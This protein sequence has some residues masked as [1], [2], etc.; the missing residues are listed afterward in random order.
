MLNP[1]GL[2]SVY[3]FAGQSKI[4]RFTVDI[5]HERD[6]WLWRAGV[7]IQ[8]G[9]RTTSN[10]VEGGSCPKPNWMKM[11]AGSSLKTEGYQQNI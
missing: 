9:K 6:A 2:M 3:A 4:N 8:I 11:V 10:G 7:P 1:C 5:M